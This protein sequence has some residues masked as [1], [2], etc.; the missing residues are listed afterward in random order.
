MAKDLSYFLGLR[1]RIE[2][3][4]DEDGGFV[5][6][7]PE[8]RGCIAQGETADEAVQNLRDA[9]AAWIQVRL[10]DGLSVPEPREQSSCSGRLLLR[11]PRSLHE[12]LADAAER[13]GVSLNQFVVAALS[14]HV[15]NDVEAQRTESWI[16]HWN[17]KAS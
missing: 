2:L 4:E 9:R 11:M 6:H 8:L 7:H 5:A 12:E 14:R 17:R 10:E 3:E 15:W 16:G 1:Y 13:D